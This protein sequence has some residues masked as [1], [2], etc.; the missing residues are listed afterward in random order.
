MFSKSYRLS[1]LDHSKIFLFIQKMLHGIVLIPY[2]TQSSFVIARRSSPAGKRFFLSINMTDM[3]SN[4]HGIFL[5][6]SH[7]FG[8]FGIKYRPLYMCFLTNISG[9][10]CICHYLHIFLASH[11]HFNLLS[12]KFFPLVFP[13]PYKH[14]TLSFP[15]SGSTCTLLLC[16]TSKEQYSKRSIFHLPCPTPVH[17]VTMGNRSYCGDLKHHYSPM[18]LLFISSTNLTWM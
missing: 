1:F 14:A 7:H 5:T 2:V 4:C 10:N 9:S 17:M 12:P 18:C 13:P 16:M 6:P 8:L 11:A 3:C 15:I